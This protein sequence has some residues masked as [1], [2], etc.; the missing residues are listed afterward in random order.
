MVLGGTADPIQRRTGAFL[1]W[2]PRRLYEQEATLMPVGLRNDIVR[3]AA[4]ELFR[5]V[6]DLVQAD[7]S[8]DL[9]LRVGPSALCTNMLATTSQ[10]C[11][12]NREKCNEDERPT[13]M[14]PVLGEYPMLV[15]K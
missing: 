8:Y 11:N 2:S 10:R 15:L 12:K 5:A 1:F 7:G 13:P 6:H 9:E 14:P 3:L 4:E